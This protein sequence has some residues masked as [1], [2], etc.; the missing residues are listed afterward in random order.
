M[1]ATGGA[2][3]E[4]VVKLARRNTTPLAVTAPNKAVAI[5]IA[6]PHSEPKANKSSNAPSNSPISSAWFAK[7]LMGTFQ[8]SATTP[9]TAT[10]RPAARAFSNAL[11]TCEY[12]LA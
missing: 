2:A 5:G 1:S 8:V 12:G 9:P 7:A 3:D 11:F 4:T 6:I 10:V